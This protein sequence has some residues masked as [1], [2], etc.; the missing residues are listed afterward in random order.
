M[1]SGYDVVGGSPDEHCAGALA[2][3][4]LRV[5]FNAHKLVGQPSNRSM[6]RTCRRSSRAASLGI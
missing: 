5:P 4:G 3:G 2:L 6:A 1:S